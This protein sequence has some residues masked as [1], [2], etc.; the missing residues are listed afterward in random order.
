MKG[1]KKVRVQGS[2]WGPRACRVSN[3]F[4][5]W[6]RALCLG[7]PSAQGPVAQPVACSVRR[8]GEG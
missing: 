6:R 3:S 1:A 8:R 2:A 5:H 7:A 4:L